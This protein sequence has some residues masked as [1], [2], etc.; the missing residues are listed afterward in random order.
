L[1]ALFLFGLAAVA[2]PVI[3]HLIHKRHSKSI[4]F[5]SLMFL[6]LIDLRMASRQKLRELI[7]L[8]LR[9]AAIALFAFALTKPILRTRTASAGARTSTTA[10]VIIDNSYSMGYK[11]SGVTGLERAREKA[12]DILG[13]LAPGDSA[14]VIPVAGYI[15]ADAQLSRDL[16]GL[17]RRVKMLK[18]N[19]SAG[20]LEGALD[21][22][23]KALASS[24]EINR[25][26]YV[27]S[28]YQHSLWNPVLE[29]GS[30]KSAQAGVV[31]VDAGARQ[32]VN[33]AIK[34]VQ[35]A[36]RP[37]EAGILEIEAQVHNHSG[38]D[39]KARVALVLDG[40]TRSEKPVT[41]PAG[42]EAS[43]VFTC[44]AGEEKLLGYV[45][46]Q[47]DG[48]A[49]DNKRFFASSAGEAIRILV[50]NGDPSDIWDIDETF[51]LATALS[52]KRSMDRMTG[53]AEAGGGSSPVKPRVVS[54]S[55]FR[56]ERLDDYAA[57]I[58][59][60]VRNLDE[61]LVSDIE[62]YVRQGGGLV[63]FS[64][65]QV[66]PSGY[67]P[68][69]RRSPETTLLPCKLI[70]SQEYPEDSQRPVRLEPVDWEH[71]IFSTLKGIRDQGFD[72]THFT[73]L[74]ICEDDKTDR[75][76]SVLARFSNG[77]P[78]LLE[79][80]H[81][82]G[83]VLYFASSCD[84]DWTNMPLRP[85]YL[86]LVHQ[87]VRY[88]SSRQQRLKSY[89]V[90]EPVKYTFPPAEKKAEVTVTD[91]AGRAFEAK[92]EPAG[93]AITATFSE[94]LTPGIYNTLIRSST[95]KEGEYFAVN[96]DV[97]EG[98][99]S[100]VSRAQAREL[101]GPGVTQLDGEG[102]LAAAIWRMRTGVK[103]WDYFF[104]LALL[105]L[106]AEGWLANRFVP[107]TAGPQT[108]P[109]TQIAAKRSNTEKITVKQGV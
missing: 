71:A 72:T 4:D 52:P 36:H 59:A 57:V 8:A 50:V 53:G 98:D 7:I 20:S 34:G 109:G 48:L 14:S 70:G 94:T 91:P 64:G 47:T 65:D 42:G 28:D 25:E 88:I 74:M 23:L 61:M 35:I 3:I 30:L 13:T 55:G 29:A 95:G 104:Y 22:A 87:M 39:T 1:N 49:T 73:K 80:K 99:L 38:S 81:G 76:V 68:A 16:A 86:P 12:Q 102:D 106:L 21:L 45:F 101:L 63:I 89:L 75:A 79:R 51:Y 66:K 37:G 33:M 58:M 82:A 11:E 15:P 32:P 96:V 107:H 85:I 46:L 105:A 62:E 78:A 27:I 103:L 6:R 97:S 18:E 9:I 92:V 43:A 77:F 31:L 26:L 5:P 10:V 90:S 41:V 84:R 24:T 44:G 54:E 108:R 100:R 56:N 93:G 40:K 19:P 67:N 2:V 60:N 83:S 69:L 17:T